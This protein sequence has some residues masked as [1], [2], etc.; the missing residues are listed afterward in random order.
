MSNPVVAVQ[1]RAMREVP[2]AFVIHPAGPSQFINGRMENSFSLTR[3]EAVALRKE[4]DD[5]LGKV[6][7]FTLRDDRAFEIRAAFQEVTGSPLSMEST[8][9]ILAAGGLKIETGW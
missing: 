5:A 4:L 6:S 8:A 1:Q 7:P 3:A 2:E 9:K